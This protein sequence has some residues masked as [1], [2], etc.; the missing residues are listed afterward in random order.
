MTNFVNHSDHRGGVLVHHRVIH[1][2][3]AECVESAFLH[4][5]TV[6]A[7]F[8]LSDFNLSHFEIVV[9]G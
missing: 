4:S 1:F 5:G 8:Y 3:K 9:K 2:L 7:A 6:D